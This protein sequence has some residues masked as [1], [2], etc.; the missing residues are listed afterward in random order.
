[1]YLIPGKG[2]F[3]NSG[4]KVGSQRKIALWR[5]FIMGAQHDNESFTLLVIESRVS[6]AI[7][8]EQFRKGANSKFATI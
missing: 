6:R 3:E 1:M 5:A 8:V 4:K 7:L 2:W